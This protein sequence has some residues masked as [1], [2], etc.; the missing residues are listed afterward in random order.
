LGDVEG[1][2]SLTIRVSRV[3]TSTTDDLD[4]GVEVDA[5]VARTLSP[6]VTQVIHRHPD[7]FVRSVGVECSTD[8]A[9]D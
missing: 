5:E 9:P 6:R 1:E 3:L 7:V 8:S 2:V 4:Q